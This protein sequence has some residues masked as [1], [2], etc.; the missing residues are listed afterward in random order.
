MGTVSTSSW[1]YVPA[2]LDISK[3]IVYSRSGSNS[4]WKRQ[5][6]NVTLLSLGFVWGPDHS[7]RPGQGSENSTDHKLLH[8]SAI[9]K[10]LLPSRQAIQTNNQIVLGG[11]MTPRDNRLPT[12]ASI[13]GNDE[14]YVC[15]YFICI[16]AHSDRELSAVWAGVIFHWHPWRKSW[17]DSE[18][19][20]FFFFFFS[21]CV[22]VLE[23][24]LAGLSRLIRV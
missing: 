22:R 23:T 21:W 16:S 15:L 14:V 2:A 8:L 10:C 20:G 12:P 4:E 24:G 5:K 19:P 6:M 9:R 1:L 7:H 18:L 13:K 3:R 11:F 17:L